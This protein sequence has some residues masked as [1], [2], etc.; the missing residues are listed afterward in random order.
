MRAKVSAAA[1]GNGRAGGG[2][3]VERPRNTAVDTAQGLGRA[4]PSGRRVSEQKRKQKR[5]DSI[6]THGRARW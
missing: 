6:R 1:S 2:E 4:K 5:T 3:E